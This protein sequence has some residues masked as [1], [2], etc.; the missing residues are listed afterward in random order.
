[1]SLKSLN[2]IRLI[3]LSVLRDMLEILVDRAKAITDDDLLLKFLKK[4][5][6]DYAEVGR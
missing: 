6:L 4:F 3:L 1:M 5:A 2:Y